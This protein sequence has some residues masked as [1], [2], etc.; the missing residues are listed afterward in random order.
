MGGWRSVNACKVIMRVCGLP[1]SKV[2]AKA[3]AFQGLLPIA[4]LA[5]GHGPPHTALPDMPDVSIHTSG[6][7]L[8]VLSE[9]LYRVCL[10]NGKVVCAHLSKAL[11]AQGAGFVA[12]D[13]LR[14]E[15]TPYD[16]DTARILGRLEQGKEPADAG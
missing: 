11:C 3:T 4:M 8:E 2:I 7:V 9:V 1:S 12:G 13:S 16:F 14:L 15:M 6:E 10:P 5:P